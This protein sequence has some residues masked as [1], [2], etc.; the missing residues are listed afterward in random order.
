MMSYKGKELQRIAMVKLKHLEVILAKEAE[1]KK[2][3]D[4]QREIERA[5][6]ERSARILHELIR[7]LY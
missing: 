2:G 5:R 4:Q 1:E 6:K 3:R 7:R